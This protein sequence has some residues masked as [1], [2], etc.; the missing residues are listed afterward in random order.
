ML[1]QL[2]VLIMMLF[3]KVAT[4]DNAVRKAQINSYENS[5][6]PRLD[7]ET[8]YAAS[9]LQ[10]SQRCMA[11]VT[12]CIGANVK[13]SAAHE[14]YECEIVRLAEPKSGMQEREGWVHMEVQSMV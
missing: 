11:S 14:G 2:I 6:L 1:K 12:T 9:M 10:C 5:Y 4:I 7:G 3:K 8:L 13:T